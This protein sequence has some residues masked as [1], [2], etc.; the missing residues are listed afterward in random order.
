MACGM[1]L[2]DVVDSFFL[3][4]CKSCLF[5]LMNSSYVGQPDIGVIDGNCRFGWTHFGSQ[6]YKLFPQS[7]NW[8]TALVKC[9]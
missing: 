6:C 8:I 1:V 4:R 9:Y 5:L 3:C 2:S 7:T